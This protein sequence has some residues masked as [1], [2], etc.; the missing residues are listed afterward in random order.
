ME[1]KTILSTLLALLTI[2][3]LGAADIVKYPYIVVLEGGKS[4]S[5][6]DSLFQR[7]A[8]KV[9]FP[10]NKSAIPDSAAF[11]LELRDELTPYFNDNA[12]RL[13]SMTLRGA[14]S[15]EGRYAHNLQLSRRR[16]ET[17]LA[18]LQSLGAQP[19]EGRVDT[20]VVAEDYDHLLQLM[21]ERRDRD[22]ARVAAVYARFGAARPALLK[23]KLMALDKR[24]VWNRL[25][26]E[27]FPKLRA[28]R[29]VL[30]FRKHEAPA[31][32]PAPAENVPTPQPQP[33]PTPEPAPA[34]VAE[35]LP[36]REFLSIKTN[37]LLDLAYMPGYNRFCPIPNVAL[38]YYPR[39]G[40]WTFGGSFDFPWWQDY[41]AHKYFQI[42]NYQL[43][44]RYYLRSG[45]VARRGYGKGAAFQGWYAQAYTHVGLYSIC[46]DARRGWEGEGL[47]GG[48]GLGYVVPLGKRGHW[49]L[50]LAAQLGVFF[51]K[52]DPY[53]YECPVDPTE[54]DNLYYYKWT[55]D[56]NLF[57]RR[58]HHFTWTGPTRVGVTLSYDLLY[59]RRA[60]KGVSLNSRE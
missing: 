33:E 41:D 32:Q 39:R 13:E 1:K 28:A 35:S 2:P 29:A 8:R 48:I 25:L 36:R 60:K 19:L 31:P 57:R 38:E 7:I 20:D 54:H 43:E 37:L 42:R 15:P 5:I 21:K 44:T 34:V 6:S 11:R 47:G 59:R 4:A 58:Q 14:A 27:Y 17:L 3:N 18:L 51:T 24:R 30:F 45:D 55:L 23:S 16:V 9:V 52:Y 50:E 49:R 12:F 53:Q 10:V 40:H 26:K 56:C 22:Y 46:F